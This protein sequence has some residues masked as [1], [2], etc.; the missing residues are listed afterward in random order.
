MAVDLEADSLFLRVVDG[1][2]KVAEIITS[3]PEE[4]R[5]RA[6]EAAEQSYVKSACERG[7][8]EVDARA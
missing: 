5:L 4:M 6:L 7:Y 2:P 3:L 1:L 8:E